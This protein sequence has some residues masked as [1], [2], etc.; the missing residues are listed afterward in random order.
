MRPQDWQSG[1]QPWVVNVIAPEACP[2]PRSG[3]GAEEMIKDTKANVFADRELKYLV[4]T[5]AGKE[6]RGA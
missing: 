6:V 1:D 3:G 4:T 5:G 2:G